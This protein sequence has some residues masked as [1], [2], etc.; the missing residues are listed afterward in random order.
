[1][2]QNPYWRRKLLSCS[3]DDI[4]SINREHIEGL[5]AQTVNAV[6]KYQLDYQVRL[7]KF[8]EAPTWMFEGETIVFYFDAREFPSVFLQS[9]NNRSVIGSVQSRW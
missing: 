9:A 6:R 4:F 5:S 2:S 1:M 7:A 8:N 3:A